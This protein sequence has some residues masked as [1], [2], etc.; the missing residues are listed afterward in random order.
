M[1][2]ETLSEISKQIVDK[3]YQL[4]LKLSTLEDQGR[5]YGYPSMS[6]G[7][8]KEC[9]EDNYDLYESSIDLANDL[10]NSE[11]AP[12]DKM[13]AIIKEVRTLVRNKVNPKA[14]ATFLNT[15]LRITSISNKFLFYVDEVEAI[16]LDESDATEENLDV[17]LWMNGILDRMF[18]K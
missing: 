16:K 5:E 15:C 11:E 1:E 17:A 6:G 9:F 12:E 4:T 10:Y 18:T 13:V 8:Y 2:Q 3:L 14:V 7:K